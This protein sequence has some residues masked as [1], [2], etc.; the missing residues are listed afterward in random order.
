MSSFVRE[1]SQLHFSRP[2]LPTLFLSFSQVLEHVLTGRAPS[3]QPDVASL[4]VTLCPGTKVAD[5]DPQPAEIQPRTRSSNPAGSNPGSGG[6]K[7]ARS[8]A[9]FVPPAV[10]QSDLRRSGSV[11]LAARMVGYV[12]SRIEGAWNPQVIFYKKTA[13]NERHTG[14][15]TLTLHIKLVYKVR[16]SAELKPGLVR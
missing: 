7:I 10:L 2:N 9:S 12:S 1:P 4:L 3:V 16:A 13:T 11:K 15:E 5:T 8:I 6:G 14:R